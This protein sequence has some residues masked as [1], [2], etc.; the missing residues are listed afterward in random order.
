M[1]FRSLFDVFF[2]FTLD[3]KSIMGPTLKKDNKLVPE[4]VKVDR[5]SGR[6]ILRSGRVF[7]YFVVKYSETL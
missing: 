5:D 2:L 7:T 1:P 3:I 4:G 6:L